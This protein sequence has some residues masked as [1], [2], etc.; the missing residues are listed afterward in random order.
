MYSGVMV[1]FQGLWDD[2]DI[3]THR[4]MTEKVHEHGALA[5]IELVH[6][7]IHVSNRFSRTPATA[8]YSGHQYA[9]QLD[10][11]ADLRYGFARENY[12]PE[13]TSKNGLF[14]R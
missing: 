13:S 4:L 11:P 1:I 3:P 5:G 6:G 12:Q 8:V 9:R 10:N 14:A 7:G 2:S